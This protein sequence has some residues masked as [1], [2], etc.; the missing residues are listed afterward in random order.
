MSLSGLH[1]NF[2]ILQIKD[3]Y[4]SVLVDDTRDNLSEIARKN[5]TPVKHE[6]K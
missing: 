3:Q 1:G 4:R 2:K 5:R 6:N